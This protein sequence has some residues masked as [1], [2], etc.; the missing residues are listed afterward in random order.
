MTFS[1]FTRRKKLG[2]KFSTHTHTVL[3]KRGKKFGEKI[4][5]IETQPEENINMNYG[6]GSVSRD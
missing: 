4:A 5:L 6:C 2:N 3:I 1:K